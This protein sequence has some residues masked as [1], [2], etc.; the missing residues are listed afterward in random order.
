MPSIGT[1]VFGV[2]TRTGATT[3]PDTPPVKVIDV[4][5]KRPVIARALTPAVKVAS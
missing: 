3:A 2:N 4:K 5:E 1:V